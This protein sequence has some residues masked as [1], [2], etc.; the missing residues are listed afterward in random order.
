[1]VAVAAIGLAAAAASR[2]LPTF[3]TWR[4]VNTD[5]P[6]SIVE[7]DFE[8]LGVTR[9]VSANYATHKALN[10][11]KPITQYLS[12]NLDTLSFQGRLY[13]SHGFDNI[14]EKFNTLVAW[15][16]RDPDL[17]RPPIVLFS[18]GDGDTVYFDNALSI[19]KSI[20]DIQYDSPTVTGGV[21]GIAFTINL[22]EYAE[23]S[24]EN[25]PPPETRYARAKDGEYMELLAQREYGEPL[26][27]D[28]IRKRHPALQI[29]EAGDVVKLPSFDAIRTTAV[30]PRS[31]ALQGLTLRKESDQKDVRDFHFDRNNRTFYSTVIPKGL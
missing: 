16:N 26:L 30:I 7:G 15:T 10:Q 14:T 24:L 29:V 1:M 22:E 11:F 20:S 5:V 27:G 23:F 31:I 3:R 9:N 17:R 8:A 18:V 13:Q 4:L 6:G 19:I 25:P 12:G 2:F 28:V 21:R